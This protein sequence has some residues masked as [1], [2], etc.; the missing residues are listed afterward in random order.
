ML[1][2]FIYITY[3]FC[4]ISARAREKRNGTSDMHQTDGHKHKIYLLYEYLCDIKVAAT[5]TTHTIQQKLA[6]KSSVELYNRDSTI[7]THISLFLGWM[8]VLMTYKPF[9]NDKTFVLYMYNISVY[10]THQNACIDFNSI[11]VRRTYFAM[12]GGTQAQ[13][14]ERNKKKCEGK[15]IP[16][17]LHSYSTYLF[18]LMGE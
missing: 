4:W 6:Y 7:H 10:N 1:F 13:W 8:Y 18:I 3:L 14:Y 17:I 16:I 9:I 2:S 5:T 15:K 11:I 12:V